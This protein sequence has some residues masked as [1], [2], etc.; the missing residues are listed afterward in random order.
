V[1]AARKQNFFAP[2]VTLDSRGRAS[3]SYLLGPRIRLAR[4]GGDGRVRSR[5]SMHDGPGRW[6]DPPSIATDSRDR[7][8]MAWS[9]CCG[10]RSNLVAARAARS[11]AVRGPEVLF[12][13]DAQ[14][15]G[16][17]QVVSGMDASPVA[18][19][20]LSA[21]VMVSFASAGR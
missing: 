9:H 14:A 10:K 13:G 3:V 8:V 17:P 20:P 19:W 1:V 2:D 5:L 21:G 15:F 4:L 16:D 12:A 11:G 7:V 6:P 18:V